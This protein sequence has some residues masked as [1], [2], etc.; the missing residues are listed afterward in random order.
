MSFPLFVPVGHCFGGWSKINLKVH[1]VI[2]CLNRNSVTHFVWYIEKEKRYY[3]ETLP[4]DGVSAKEHHFWV[5]WVKKTYPWEF[6]RPEVILSR[7]YLRKC[8]IWL[9]L[10]SSINLFFKNA[11]KSES[12]EANIFGIFTSLWYLPLVKITKKINEVRVTFHMELPNEAS[13]VLATVAMITVKNLCTFIAA[14]VREIHSFIK[15]M[16]PISPNY[17]WENGVKQIKITVENLLQICIL[18]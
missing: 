2:N 18:C 10:P 16:K 13:F 3:I 1:D 17:N 9:G 8:S 12:L 6:L 4:T 5:S 11:I 15:I 7:S 14:V